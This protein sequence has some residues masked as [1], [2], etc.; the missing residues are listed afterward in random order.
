MTAFPATAG[1]VERHGQKRAGLLADDE[2]DRAGL[3]AIALVPAV[4]LHD[5]A[6]REEAV[7]VLRL[8]EQVVVRLVV[9]VAVAHVDGERRKS[10]HESRQLG[11]A[12]VTGR[13]CGV[14]AL[15]EHLRRSGTGAGN[16]RAPWESSSA[17]S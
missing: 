17:I 9:G 15:P 2:R 5:R 4:H 8:A 3:D 1:V 6:S 11:G 16:A 12:R 13:L 10:W 14:L 7:G